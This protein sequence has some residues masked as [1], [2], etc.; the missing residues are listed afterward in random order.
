MITLFKIIF[1]D[2]K[3]KGG[4]GVSWFGIDVKKK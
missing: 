4:G 3:G 1:I 2:V